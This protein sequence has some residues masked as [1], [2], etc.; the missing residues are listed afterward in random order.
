MLG[1]SGGIEPIFNLSY[2]RKTES[3]HGEDV[4][5]KVYTPIVQEF[6]EKAGITDE[7]YLP[8][9]FVTAMTLKPIER[10]RMQAAWQQNIDASISSTVNLPNEA[11]VEDVYD[12]YMNAWKYGL[13]GITIYRDGCARGGVLI[14]EKKEDKKITIIDPM[15]EVKATEKTTTVCPECGGEISHSGGC[16]VC[17]NCGYSKCN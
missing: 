14:N 3:L 16:G 6:M 7:D 17:L 8:E 11:T 9:T 12:V 13:K 1:I 5:Y 15:K 4:Y 2:I 10:V